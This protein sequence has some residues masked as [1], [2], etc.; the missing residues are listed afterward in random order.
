M[1]LPLT[2]GGG[3]TVGSTPGGGAQGGVPVGGTPGGGAQGGAPVG[4][5][6]GGSAQYPVTSPVPQC[7]LHS[8]MTSVGWVC[9]VHVVEGQGRGK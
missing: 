5:T 8:H 7:L 1:V 9:A 2:P 3:A 6:P 4:G